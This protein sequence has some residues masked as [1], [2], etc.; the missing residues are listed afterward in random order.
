MKDFVKFCEILTKIM[1]KSI[2]FFD[3]FLI[4]GGPGPLPDMKNDEKA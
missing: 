2:F 1:K 3:F 4:P